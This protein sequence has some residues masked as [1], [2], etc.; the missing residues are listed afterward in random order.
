MKTNTEGVVV[1]TNSKDEVVG[2]VRKDTKTQKN[3]VYVVSDAKL[4]QIADMI[5]GKFE[6][7]TIPGSI[8]E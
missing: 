2:I 4:D 5:T 6:E 1:I 3:L 7:P 8:P